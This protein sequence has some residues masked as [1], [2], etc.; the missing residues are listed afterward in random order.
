MGAPSFSFLSMTRARLDI[1]G[2]PP[3]AAMPRE[4]FREHPRPRMSIKK[5]LK[6]RPV[7]IN[8]ENSLCRLIFVAV[9]QPLTQIQCCQIRTASF[10]AAKCVYIDTLSTYIHECSGIGF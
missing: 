2:T 3:P 9:I 8:F 5:R 4:N 10:T 1:N 7:Y 6:E